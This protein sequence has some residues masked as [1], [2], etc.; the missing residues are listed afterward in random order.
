MPFIFVLAFGWWERSCIL[1]YKHYRE[2]MC[3]NVTGAPKK[4]GHVEKLMTWCFRVVLFINREIQ[5]N[6][7]TS[8]RQLW[9]VKLFENWLGTR[10]DYIDYFS[11]A[12]RCLQRWLS[13]STMLVERVHWPLTHMSEIPG[14]DDMREMSSC[15]VWFRLSIPRYPWW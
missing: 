1:F 8:R 11:F 3:G 9:E 7:L 14:K 12:C 13:K 5:W 15:A 10:G 4:K 6:S 2:D